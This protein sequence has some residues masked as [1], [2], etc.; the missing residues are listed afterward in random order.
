MTSGAPKPTVCVRCGGRPGILAAASRYR[1]STKPTRSRSASSR[2]ARILLRHASCIRSGTSCGTAFNTSF[3]PISPLP[4]VFR[5]SPVERTPDEGGEPVPRPLAS[6]SVRHATR[7]WTELP[8]SRGGTPPSSDSYPA[9]G[10][11]VR[12]REETRYGQRERDQP[13]RRHLSPSTSCERAVGH[14]VGA[15]RCGRIGPAR[16]LGFRDATAR[17]RNTAP[18]IS[19]ATSPAVHT[20]PTRWHGRPSRL[21]ARDCVGVGRVGHHRLRPHPRRRPT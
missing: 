3:G 1:L 15:H 19:S 16:D 17:P 10:Q 2:P 11:S 4:L 12:P 13:T 8:H 6:R 18:R 5:R 9:E 20:S 7:K 14:V 21:H